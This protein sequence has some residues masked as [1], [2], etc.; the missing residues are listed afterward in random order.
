[1][2]KIF[3]KIFFI[4]VILVVCMMTA[5]HVWLFVQPKSSDIVSSPLDRAKGRS[6][7]A[8]R[9]IEYVDFRC[10]PCAHGAGWLKDVMQRHPDKF[11]LEVHYF[12]LSFKHGVLAERFAECALSQGRFWEVFD[13]LMSRQAEW[14]RLPDPKPYY[15]TIARE[16]DLDIDRLDTCWNDP[17][18]YDAIVKIKAEGQTLGISATPTYFI[19][20]QKVVGANDLKNTVNVLLGLDRAPH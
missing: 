10:G 1:M 7:A 4:V 5:Y 12:P 11:F 20:D 9:I 17:S 16:Y 2:T 13:A 15:L 18:V 8:I 19:N 6:Q 14:V 3:G